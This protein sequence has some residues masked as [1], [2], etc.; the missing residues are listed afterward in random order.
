MCASNGQVFWGG[1]TLHT[2]SL[3]WSFWRSSSLAKLSL[4]G[5][6]LAGRLLMFREDII[7]KFWSDSSSGR[8]R[9]SGVA[10]EEQRGMIEVSE[11]GGCDDPGRK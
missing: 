3:I 5:A 2:T 9:E 4:E 10:K 1:G 11:D 8:A 6:P 7:L